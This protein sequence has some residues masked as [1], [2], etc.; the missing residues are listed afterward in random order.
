MS[1]RN[2]LL[3]E[4]LSATGGGGTTAIYGSYSDT[5]NQVFTANVSGSVVFDTNAEQF[6]IIHS[7][8][9]D[10]E[11]FEFPTAGIYQFS[12]EPQL[13]RV[14]GGGFDTMNV[15]MEL[16]IGSGFNL[17]PNSNIKLE[18]ASTGATRVAALTAAISIGSGDKVRYRCQVTDANFILEAF[19]A[20]GVAPNDIPATPS[21]ILNIAKVN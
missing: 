21:V 8:T 15:F 5:A 17:I 3:E 16:D 6:G 2:E 7:E 10:S 14:A 20:S 1:I 4:I 13:T 19:P 9:I 11:V 18:T 12:V